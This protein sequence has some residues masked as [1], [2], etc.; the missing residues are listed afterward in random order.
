MKT[1]NYL[2]IQYKP[3]YIIYWFCLFLVLP[4]N[5]RF[6]FLI[7]VLFMWMLLCCGQNQYYA[8]NFYDLHLSLKP[9]CLIS[10]IALWF[11]SCI[12][13]IFDYLLVNERFKPKNYKK[14]FPCSFSCFE[15]VLACF[16]CSI[17]KFSSTNTRG[18]NTDI[19]DKHCDVFYSK[20]SFS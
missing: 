19:L 7:K 14:K 12:I 9:L 2:Y 6:H 18:T 11:S 4:L 20:K 16:L 17:G 3:L 10:L 13:L 1:E 5:L 8:V 15:I